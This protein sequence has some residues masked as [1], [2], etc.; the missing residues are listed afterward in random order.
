MKRAGT[1]RRMLAALLAA[2]MLLGMLPAAAAETGQPI[3][4][5]DFEGTDALFAL[6]ENW[7]V[8]ETGDGHALQGRVTGN[9]GALTLAENVQLPETYTITYD[10]T[11]VEAA[12]A[13]GWSGGVVFGYK[14][15]SNFHHFRFN[16]SSAVSNVQVMQW[17]D[18]NNHVLA[19]VDYPFQTGEGTSHSLCLINEAGKARMY[20]DGQLLAEDIPVESAG[21]GLGL[22]IY[23]GTMRFDNVAVWDEV[24]EPEVPAG[25]VLYENTFDTLPGELSKGWEVVELTEGH[26]LQGTDTSTTGMLAAL[27][28]VENLPASYTLVLDMALMEGLSGAGYSA[29]LT[30]GHADSKNFY[31][32]RLDN[33]TGKNAQLYR[34]VNGSV[35]KNVAEDYP[36]SDLADGR[37]YRLRVTVDGQSVTCYLDGVQTQACTV[38]DLTGGIGLRVYN[39]EVLFDN[40]TVY[41]G[42]VLP[43]EGGESAPGFVFPQAEPVV[44]DNEDEGY[45][46]TAGEW[47]ALPGAG[48]DRSDARV[49]DGGAATF[50]TYPPAEGTQNYAVEWYVPAEDGGAVSFTVSTLDGMWKYDL[51]AGTPAGWVSLGVVTATAGTAFTVTASSE[52]K[53]YADAIRLTQTRTDADEP[54]NPAGGGS[55]QVAVLVNQIGYDIGKPMRAT[56]PNAADGT[57]FLVKNAA[58][59]ETVY[60]GTVQGNIADFSDVLAPASDTDYYIT[61]AGAQSYTFTVGENLIQR[62]SVVNALAFMNETRSD[63]FKVGSNSIG[64]RDSHQFSFEL[65]SMAL[66]YMANPALYDSLPPSIIETESCE[67]EELRVQDEPDIVWLI[68][69]AALR[70]YDWGHNEGKKLHMLTKEQLAYFLYIYPEISKWVD[71]DTYTAIRDYTISVWG[72]NACNVQW[73]PVANSNHDLYSVQ[74]IFGGL[75]GSQPPGHSIVPNL[76]MYEVALRDGLGQDVAD[77]FFQAAYD[78]CVYTITEIDINDPFYNKGQ[79]MSEHVTI[80]GLAWFLEMYPDRAPDG[81]KEALERWADT[82]IARSNNLWDI[83]MAVCLEAGDGQYEFHNPKF[84]EEQKKI[85]QDYWTGAA[86]A[87]ADKQGDY[88]SGGAPKN[89]P[90]NQAGLQAVTY[91]AARV[92]DDPEVNERLIEL[93]VAAID[94]LYGRNPTGR[95]AFYH[96]TRDFEGADLGWYKQYPGGAG[97]LGGHT[98]VIDANAP[99]AC[100]PYNPEAYDTGYTEGWVAYN[101]AWNDSLAYAAADAVSLSVSANEGTVG[102]QVTVTLTAPLNM[103]PNTRETGYVW[104]ENPISGTREQLTV[105]EKGT[106]SSTFEGTCTLPDLPY[107]VVSYGSGLFRQTAEIT[108][109]DYQGTPVTGLTMDGSL[110]LG[111]GQTARLTAAVQ[112]ETA[113]DPRV[114]FTSDHPEIASVTAD[115]L[116]K[117]VSAG[118]AVITAKS[119]S[120]PKITA[121]C[122]VTVA[123]AVPTGLRLD[124]P[125]DLSVF[126]GT[127]QAAVAAVIYSD[128]AERTEDL[129]QAVFSTEDTDILTV[130]ADGAITPLSAGEA[131]VTA[132]AQV[133]GVTVTGSAAVTVTADKRYDLMALYNEDKYT[134]DGVTLAI[135]ANTNDDLTPTYGGDRVKLTGNAKGNTVDF[136]LGNLAAGTY[137]VVLYSKYMGGKWAYGA[138]SFKVDGQAVGGTIDFDNEE[139]NG[140][141]HDVPLGQVTLAD[142]AHSFTFVSEDGG[143]VVPV[144][145]TLSLSGG[146]EEPD[147][148]EPGQTEP[149]IHTMD[150]MYKKVYTDASIQAD[151]LNYRLYVPAGYEHGQAEDLP[152]LIYLNGAGSRGTDNEKQLANLSP[153][154]TPLIDNEEYPCI[155]VVPQLPESDKWVNVDWAAGSYAESVAE[156]NSARLLMGLIDEL[157]QAY[158]VDG[159]R[160]YLMGQSFGGYGTWDLITRHPE[161]FA[162]AVPMCGAGCL[163]RAEAVTDMPLLVLHGSADPTVPVSGSREM[164]DAIQKAGGKLVTYLEYEGDDHYVQR[165]LFEQPGLWMEWLFAQEKGVTAQAPDVSSCFMPETTLNLNSSGQLDQLTVTGGTAAIN[166]A[167][168]VLTPAASNASVL[169]LVKGTEAFADGVLTAHITMEELTASGGGG[170]VLRAQS[171]DTYIHI[172][173]TKEGL[174]LLEMVDG[175]VKQDNTVECP[176]VGDRIALMTAQ[177]QGSHIK[178]WV[179]N[180]LRFDTEI[181]TDELKTSGAVGVRT[182]ALPARVDDIIW[183]VYSGP[184][185]TLTSMADRQVYQRDVATGTGTLDLTGRTSEAASLK[186]RVVTW[187]GGETVLDW[188]NVPLSADGTFSH[189]ITVPQG[190]WYKTELKAESADGSTVSASSGRWGVGINILCIGQSNMQGTGKPAPYVEA[191]DLA[192]N[193]LNERWIH[194]EDPYA[195]GDTSVAGNGNNNGASMTPALANALIEEY[196]VPVGIIPAAKSGA[197]LVCDCSAYPRWLDRNPADP[198]DRSNLYGNS[199]YRAKAAGGIEFILMNQGEHDV[200][201]NTTQ[202]EYLEALNT[203]VENYRTDL[204]WDVPFLYCQLG[205]AYASSWD[206]TKNSVM[207]GIRSAQMQAHDP[208]NGILLAAVEMDLARNADNLHYTTQ[209]LEVI[210]ERVA[211]TIFWYYDSDPNKTDYYLPASIST[212]RYADE[213]RTVVDV[214]VAHTGGTDI[215]PAEDITG[216]ELVAPDGGVTKPVTAVRLDSDTIRL[217]FAQPAEEGS[218]LRYLYGLLPDVTG[219]VKDNGPMAL[220]MLA[221]VE[222]VV[223]EEAQPEPPEVTGITLSQTEA[224]LWINSTPNQVQLTAQVEPEG[225]QAEVTWSSDNPEVAQ[226]DEN[227][228]VTAEGA[229]VAHITAEAGGKTAICTVTVEYA[230]APPV[231]HPEVEE[232]GHGEIE[233]SS[234]FPRQGQ[235]VTITPEPEEGYE[236]ESLTVTDRNGNP[237]EVTEQADGTWRFVQPVGEVTITAEFAPVEPVT[238]SD[239]EAGSWYEEAV[240]AMVEAGLMQGTGSGMFQPFGTV[241]RATMWTIL[242][243]MDGADT[244]GGSSW[245]EKGQAWA[246]AQDVSDGTNPDAVVTREQIAAMLYRYAGSPAA[247]GTLDFTDSGDISGWA[248]DAM[249]WAVEKGILTGTPDGKLNPQGTATR[250]EAAV[251]LLRMQEG[252]EA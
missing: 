153:L 141:Y 179:D 175:K 92:L 89:E 165:R 238:F 161:T 26:A 142:R 163:D 73:Y 146:G 224:V 234:L 128:G 217:T 176:R 53:L 63:T 203:L 121:T 248:A 51:P 155:I 148:V 219:L 185:V 6:D 198:D 227:G 34:W 60:T 58:T 27:T 228:L 59:Q 159:N 30:F 226:V 147:P 109:S 127:V 252:G 166:G 138:W 18:P 246:V 172:R 158:Q 207:T 46:E 201:G 170:L 108:V 64:W 249:A 216:F 80:P 14:D 196:G 76:L 139:K 97:L 149:K 135:A 243:R 40:L 102:S 136:D 32:Y 79:R 111:A 225:A 104:V 250:A 184:S 110:T 7:T 117:A 39:A 43:P 85:T 164:V 81:L 94:D 242:A 231:Y 74:T 210:G 65:P 8:V 130:T 160:V 195:N 191:H 1:I 95:A 54:Y 213:S 55:D 177:V 99:E 67:Y 48:Q 3:F 36:V 17:P 193:F 174:N 171:D 152:L 230:Y 115:G 103:D 223:I 143:P 11:M 212:V 206:D 52:G 113:T 188:F 22:R 186:A 232:E 86:Y 82:T 101:T 2:V 69:F 123:A 169:A 78:N 75:K 42:A 200:S 25:A 181:Q 118:T 116:V 20:V 150:E 167:Q 96:F 134:A 202:A 133:D 45:Q 84:T 180:V 105:T 173:F 126:E 235:I 241:T 197:G 154:I 205:P 221:T 72:E 120:N 156:S 90:G 211:N 233:V 124:V 208:D 106:D 151:G 190:G 192:S 119:V 37:A 183:S 33:G 236:L 247:E 57:E 112:P 215:T 245:Y 41:S 56:V 88:L 251:M 182:Y 209:S 49:A 21:N 125:A 9:S 244:E 214:D 222:P 38:S 168:L 16:K 240:S 62:R 77:R 157:K 199:L 66:Q 35:D 162:A 131:T 71:K 93:G 220:P 187:D 23:N 70:Y 204:G 87:N 31:H 145:L 98:A 140:T 218:A 239:V 83:R 15:G 68:Q 144:Y 107:V 61:C 91:A 178:V 229:G 114:T 12:T 100:Y 5:A 19:Q 28:S 137:D 50:S 129:P 44:Y 122:T 29:G 237:V 132:S 10:F 47:S 4:Q 24:R 189:A 13:N 194:L